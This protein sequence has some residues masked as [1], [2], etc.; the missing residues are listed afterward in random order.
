MIYVIDTETDGLHTHAKPWL[1]VVN[2]MVFWLPVDQ[3][4]L[5]CLLRKLGIDD[6]LVG[7][8]IHFDLRVLAMNGYTIPRCRIHDV[9]V[10]YKSDLGLKQLHA[11]VFGGSA[12]ERDELLEALRKRF[13][14][15]LK[16]ELMPLAHHEPKLAL[17]YCKRDVSMTAELYK[18]LPTRV[19]ASLDFANAFRYSVE[20]Y[21]R[22]TLFDRSMLERML[23]WPRPIIKTRVIVKKGKDKGKE[24]LGVLN[25]N[26]YVQVQ[27]Y[28]GI[29]T[30]TSREALEELATPEAQNV[31]RV[32]SF[33]SQRAIA[34]SILTKGE[35]DGGP[36]I[37]VRCTERPTTITGRMT[38]TE[39]C[40]HQ[41]PSKTNGRLVFDLKPTIRPY[42]N[43]YLVVAD[44]SQIELRILACIIHPW[45]PALVEAF[46]KGIDVHTLNA[47][48]IF[49]NDAG[50]KFLTSLGASAK[51]ISRTYTG[52]NVVEAEQEL[53]G[54]GIIRKRTKNTVFALIYGA[55]VDKVARMTK[56]AVGDA[57]KT[58]RLV[59]STLFL[60]QATEFC[61]QAEQTFLLNRYVEC[62][63]M[64]T[65]LNRTIQGTAADALH[66]SVDRLEAISGV[67]TLLTIHD[68]LW[69]SVKELSILPNICNA[70]RIRLALT[71]ESAL[72]LT[73]EPEVKEFT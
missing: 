69:L 66:M 20:R 48:M 51:Q 15:Y 16:H 64:R 60:N 67:K 29:T 3:K 50:E 19:K 63:P 42:K 68:E 34:K 54:S 62:D 21:V 36:Y 49:A 24:I 33:H 4:K 39:P 61:R 25:C 35:S 2:D 73:A 31:L 45:N 23:R 43:E 57:R 65:L 70:L 40:L 12:V 32:R 56:S 9:M 37:T 59:R 27:R 17:K 47:N 22:G 26:S 53:L 7:F 11:K 14:G 8:N 41:M 72:D 38:S 18:A 44:F 30:A 55:G 5:E 46:R 71:K 13:P 58:C 1:V 10:A 52:H 28:L 6:V